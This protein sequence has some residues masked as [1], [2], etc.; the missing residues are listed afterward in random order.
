MVRDRVQLGAGGVAVRKMEGRMRN[1]EG[2]LIVVAT[3][4]LLLLYLASRLAS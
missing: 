2:V 3:V 1:I 4:L